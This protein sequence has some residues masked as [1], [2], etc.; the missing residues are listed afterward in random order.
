MHV[1][2]SSSLRQLT[3]YG[4]F[5]QRAEE[6]VAWAWFL[7]PLELGFRFDWL[8]EGI[9]RSLLLQRLTLGRRFNRPN[10]VAE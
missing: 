7:Q 5:N 8:V 2:W 6:V 10:E 1:V 4:Y 9:T 3:F